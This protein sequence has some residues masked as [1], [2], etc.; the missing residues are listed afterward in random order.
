M[1]NEWWYIAWISLTCATNFHVTTNAIDELTD[2]GRN[3]EET[4]TDSMKRTNESKREIER[5]NEAVK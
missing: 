3:K 5:A 2:K 4:N 1:K